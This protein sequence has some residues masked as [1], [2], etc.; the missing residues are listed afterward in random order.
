MINLPVVKLSG[1]GV[2]FKAFLN[3][4]A[5]FCASSESSLKDFGVTE[6]SGVPSFVIIFEN[7][8]LICFIFSCDFSS[9]GFASINCLY[10][11][12]V[13]SV[14]SSGAGVFSISSFTVVFL[15]FLIIA[16]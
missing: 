15:R 4:I 3:S 2:L 7:F 5:F 12:L 8:S 10:A 14:S 1:I 9:G 6:P 13:V 11:F 16:L